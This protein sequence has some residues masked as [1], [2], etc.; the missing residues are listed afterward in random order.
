MRGHLTQKAIRGLLMLSLVGTASCVDN[1]YDLSKDIDMTVTFGGSDLTLPASNTD[2]ITLEKIF[3]L[4][5]NSAVQPLTAADLADFPGMQEGDYVLLKGTDT[6]TENRVSVNEVTVPM[7][8][9][10]RGESDQLVFVNPASIPGA[11]LENVVLDVTNFR[12]RSRLYNENVTTDVKSIRW[13]EIELD[14]TAGLRFQDLN[15]ATNVNRL[16]LKR[17]FTLTFPEGVLLMDAGDS[18]ISVNANVMTLNQDVPLSRNT[19]LLFRVKAREIS[20]PD[21]PAP[22]EGLYEVGKFDMTLGVVG[23]GQAYMTPAD[24]PSGSTQ[25]RLQVLG[26]VESTGDLRVNRFRGI[27]DPTI[28]IELDPV[29]ITGIPDFL[30]NEETSLDVTNPVIKFNVNNDTPMRV[31]LN[32]TLQALDN[33]GNLLAQ[34]AIGDTPDPAIPG[35]TATEPVLLETGVQAIRLVRHKQAGE[36]S[37]VVE[38]AAIN[39]LIE[40][41]PGTLQ[42]VNV[43]AR[44]K[45]DVVDVEIGTDRYSVTTGARM[46]APLSFGRNMNLVYEDTLDGW[47]SDIKDLEVKKL[48][49]EIEGTNQIPLDLRMWFDATAG[50][51]PS[52]VAIDTDGNPIDDIVVTINK[53]EGVLGAGTPAAPTVSLVKLTLTSKTGAM[54]TLDGL[55]YRLRGT[56][57]ATHEHI[58]LNQSQALILDKVRL[59]VKGGLTMDLN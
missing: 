30:Q 8:T 59:R 22:G 38:V 10:Q 43:R 42:I 32:A 27:V 49:V 39:D 40:R 48:E 58:Q 24:F 45:E 26:L 53:A 41:I 14:L 4:D 16:Y 9:D 3:D 55:C 44:A 46:E 35:L 23:E 33:E 19:P 57:P 1:D 36:G 29:N 12:T 34:V 13:A 17:G 37:N 2:N 56:V 6:D 31:N 28:D 21:S 11:P 54:K 5:E 15:G 25:V 18:R 20:F 50:E 51:T 52:V 7:T 47:N